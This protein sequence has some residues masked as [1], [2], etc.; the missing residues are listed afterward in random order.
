MA[1]LIL[2]FV[3]ED[4]TLF[5]QS[6]SGAFAWLHPGCLL[7]SPLSSRPSAAA[8]ESKRNYL[9]TLTASTPAVFP[10]LC[11]ARLLLGCLKGASRVF[12]G[13]CGCLKAYMAV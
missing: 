5:E 13:G 8:G 2:H 9:A 7:P 1:C 12:I 10:F 4:L 11:E 6:T 3:S